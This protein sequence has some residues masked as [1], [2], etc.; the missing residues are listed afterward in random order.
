[1]AVVE[2]EAE[3]WCAVAVDSA[4]D[5]ASVRAGAP[6]VETVAHALHVAAA[7]VVVV[8]VVVVAEKQVAKTGHEV[9]EPDLDLSRSVGGDLGRSP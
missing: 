8:V 7:A 3:R 5:A 1:M 4:Q 6:D 9:A 2:W